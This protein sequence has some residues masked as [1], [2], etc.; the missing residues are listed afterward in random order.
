MTR[1]TL[2]DKLYTEVLL[3]CN[4]EGCHGLF[5]STEPARDPMQ[6]WSERAANEAEQQGWSVSREGVVACPKCARGAVERKK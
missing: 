5:E 6:S 3:A 1:R 4:T 2:T